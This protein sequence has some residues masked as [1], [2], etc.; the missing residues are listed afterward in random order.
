MNL[1]TYIAFVYVTPF[2][3]ISFTVVTTFICGHRLHRRLIIKTCSLL[4]ST[5]ALP[6]YIVTAA[7]AIHNSRK[8]ISR[9]VLNSSRA[10]SDLLRKVVNLN[11]KRTFPGRV[12]L[13]YRLKEKKTVYM[14]PASV[15]YFT[16]FQKIHR[17]LFCFCFLAI[18]LSITRDRR[19]PRQKI[20]TY[21]RMLRHRS[22]N[23]RHYMYYISILTEV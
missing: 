20:R 22:S 10:E 8:M 1:L 21:R 3:S 2:F 11:P 6:V 18:F 15:C 9:R 13:L 23:P 16:S 4:R 17:L 12:T 5:S 19:K 7:S 14:S